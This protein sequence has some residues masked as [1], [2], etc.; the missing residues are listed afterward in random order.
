MSETPET[1]P[2]PELTARLRACSG[3]NR[4][5]FDELV[6][7]VYEQLRVIARAQLRRSPQQTMDTTGLVHETYLKLAGSESDNWEDRAHFFAASA[8]A[9]RHILVDA[10]RRRLSQKRGAGERPKSITSEELKDERAHAEEVLA[11]HQALDKIRGID[12]QMARIVECR[13]FGGYPAKETAMTLGISDRTER[14]LWTRAKGWLRWYLSHESSQE[15][16]PRP[17]PPS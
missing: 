2:D 1:L 12:E 3:G 7:F 10:A 4:D 11:V 8:Q 14:R 17:D 5:A 13:F 15:A 16:E 6:P 9:M